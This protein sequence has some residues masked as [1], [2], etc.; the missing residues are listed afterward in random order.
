MQHRTMGKLN[1]FRT[2]RRSRC[3][4]DRQRRGRLDIAPSGG[5]VK[6]VGRLRQRIELFDVDDVLNIGAR[7]GLPKPRQQ[8]RLGDDHLAVRLSQQAANLFGSRC[9]IDGP[10]C[11]AQMERGGIDE[12]ELRTI[13]QRHGNG[14]A[15][16]HT[17]AGQA[18]GDAVDVAARFCPAPLLAGLR[19]DERARIAPGGNSGLKRLTKRPVVPCLRTERGCFVAGDQHLGHPLALLRRT[20]P[21]PVPLG[22]TVNAYEWV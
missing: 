19:V 17:E 7:C 5:E 12:I 20:P 3:P 9:Q 10:R 14:V 13:A 8:I 15:L 2:T 22:M 1:R 6:T 21:I 11:G 4:D 18:T 16:G